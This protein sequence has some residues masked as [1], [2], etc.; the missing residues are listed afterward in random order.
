MRAARL[1]Y[2]LAGTFTMAA[3]AC[4]AAQGDAGKTPPVTPDE[5]AM[6]VGDGRYKPM[7]EVLTDLT[8]A[9]KAKILAELKMLKSGLDAAGYA[10]KMAPLDRAFKEASDAKDCEA[11]QR[12][13][14]ERGAL[15]VSYE[16]LQAR[17][18]AE[19]DP[20][21]MATLT[22]AQ[23]EKWTAQELLRLVTR[24]RD[25]GQLPEEQ[26]R[27]IREL[28]AKTS[29]AYTR[30]DAGGKQELF[31]TL[32][33]QIEAGELLTTEADRQAAAKAKEEERKAVEAMLKPSVALP[34]PRTTVQAPVPWGPGVNPGAPVVQPTPRPNPPCG[35]VPI[36][37]PTPTQP[38]VQPKPTPKPAP[39]KICSKCGRRMDF[40][41]LP[42]PEGGKWF[43]PVCG[44]NVN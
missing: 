28:C 29:P 41:V 20:K 6:S 11:M 18:V 12:I 1:F 42:I 22:A 27:Q 31:R 9:Q 37:H 7:F 39:G 19:H 10:Q 26:V 17:L 35:S 8:D 40:V 14:K 5:A 13:M 44:V 23:V 38:V 30:A 32:T 43:C 4:S 36:G 3:L 34:P 2:M 25:L 33:K 16:Q 15:R 21:I 24:G